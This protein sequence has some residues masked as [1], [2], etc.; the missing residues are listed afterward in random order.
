M[1][2]WL[3]LHNE[4]HKKSGEEIFIEKWHNL[5]STVTTAEL[6]LVKKPY[7]KINQIRF[8]FTQSFNLIYLIRLYRIIKRNRYDVVNLHNPY[9]YLSNSIILLRYLLPNVKIIHTIHNYRDFCANGLFFD[10]KNVCFDCSTK[11]SFSAIKKNCKQNIL[12]STAFSLRFIIDNWLKH[13]W[14]YHYFLVM[15]NFQLSLYNKKKIQN[16]LLIPNFIEKSQVKKIVRKKY[17]F[18]F[19][20]RI[21]DPQ[22]GFDIFLDLCKHFQNYKF[23]AI[24]EYSLEN[25]KDLSNL[26]YTGKIVKN[27]VQEYLKSCKFLIATS[28]SYEVF[29]NII[30]EAW[31]NQVIPIV[32]NFPTYKSIVKENGIIYNDEK[33]L[34][35]KIRNISDFSL[36]IEFEKALDMYSSQTVIKILIENNLV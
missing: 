24:G 23:L 35:E 2:K 6:H 34:S 10:G 32:P 13:K 33:D 1:K 22:K 20:G 16:V 18:V 17:D 14:H 8:L 21:E 25:K 12:I 27:K 4:F 30:L 28:K 11:N 29:P 5:L 7:S 19:I 3:I 31:K 9:P 36:K 26:E 15:N